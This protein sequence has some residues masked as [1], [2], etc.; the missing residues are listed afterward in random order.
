MDLQK[1]KTFRCKKYLAFVASLPCC[2]PSNLCTPQETVTYHHTSTG[3]TGLKGPDNETIPLC[4][5][6]HIEVLHRQGQGNFELLYLVKIDDLVKET[7]EQWKEAG[8][9][10][11]WL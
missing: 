2:T 8:N 9:K 4:Y 3:G 11:E 6:H 5:F 1:K 7:Q 10:A